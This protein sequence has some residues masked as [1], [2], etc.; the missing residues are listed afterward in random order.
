[1][2]ASAEDLKNAGRLCKLCIINLVER[3][4][5]F[6]PGKINDEGPSTAEALRPWR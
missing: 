4:Y 2:K 5:G 3:G 6:D 1:M